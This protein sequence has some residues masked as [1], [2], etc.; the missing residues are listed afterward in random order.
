LQE[1]V[2]KTIKTW[3]FYINCF[4]IRSDNNVARGSYSRRHCRTHTW[5]YRYAS[6][7]VV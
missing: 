3:R 2:E 1:I 7:A 6:A 5:T 4:R